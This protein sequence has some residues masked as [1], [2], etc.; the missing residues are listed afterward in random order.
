MRLL[1]LIGRIVAGTA[2][3]VGGFSSTTHGTSATPTPITWGT[4]RGVWEG[5]RITPDG[6]VQIVQLY[7]DEK[8]TLIA[9]EFISIKNRLAFCR[10][11]KVV[12][13][14]ANDGNLILQA[15]APGTTVTGWE[16][17]LLMVRGTADPGFGRLVGIV[18]FGSADPADPPVAS[19]DVE[20]IQQEE[21]VL[22]SVSAAVDSLK[23]LRRQMRQRR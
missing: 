9:C 3:I 1:S 13:H 22:A 5:L 21:P 19:W 11:W 12:V 2:V 7:Y 15:D 14:T 18:R 20:L 23:R 6:N 4:V 8:P 16:H 17:A 10:G